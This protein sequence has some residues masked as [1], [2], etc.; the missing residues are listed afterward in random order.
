GGATACTR[1]FRIGENQN[2][3]SLVAAEV[4]NGSESEVT[5]N[6]ALV[7]QGAK[8]DSVTAVAIL[9][10][11][12]NATVQVTDQQYITV[13]LSSDAPKHNFTVVFWKGA[14]KNKEVFE[15]LITNAEKTTDFPDYKNGGPAYWKQTVRTRGQLAPDTSAYVVDRLTLP[16][17]NP[18]KRN[19]RVVDVAFFEDNRAAVVTFEGDVW[20]IEGIDKELENLKWRRYASG[21]YEPQSIE[22]V[23]GMIYVFGKGGIT[24]FH[25]LNGDG[26]ADYYE[27]FSN[28]MEQSIETREWA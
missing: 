20:T 5:S 16:I 19:V 10:D 13:K 23:D 9:G 22:I 26:V 3:L 4:P 24:R 7:Y 1:S 12:Q 17:P 8:Q 27:N 28:L 21:L 2:Q 25:D 18:W 14:T 15:R 6:K 11:G